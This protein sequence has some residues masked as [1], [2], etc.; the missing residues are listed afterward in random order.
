MSSNP[1]I[2]SE[3]RLRPQSIRRT[4]FVRSIV[5]LNNI[6]LTLG[7]AFFR[8][9]SVKSGMALPPR[10]WDLVNRTPRLEYSYKWLLWIVHYY[11]NAISAL[12]CRFNVSVEPSSPAIWHQTLWKESAY[13]C[14][15]RFCSHESGRI[16]F[17]PM[18]NTGESLLCTI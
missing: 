6:Y 16:L 1:I 14:N 5:I 18:R 15:L 4:W 3:T 11:E 10:K 12:S 17:G 8:S 2:Q 7:Y 9:K 13:Q